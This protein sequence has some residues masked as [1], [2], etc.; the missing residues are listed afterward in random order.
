MT[1]KKG[2]GGS[3]SGGRKT[4]QYI[5]EVMKEIINKHVSGVSVCVLLALQY[6]MTKSTT[7]TFDENKEAIKA[8]AAMLARMMLGMGVNCEVQT[9]EGKCAS[10]EGR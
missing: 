7:S 2:K 5:M 8:V 9:Q 1:S 10:S 4:M 6:D 3:D